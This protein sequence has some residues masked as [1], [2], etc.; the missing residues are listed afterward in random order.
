MAKAFAATRMIATDRAD[1]F[2]KALVL[3]CAVALILAGQ[4][5]PY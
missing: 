4:P 2:R 1:L 5:L 3:G